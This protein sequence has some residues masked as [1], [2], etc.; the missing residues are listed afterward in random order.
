MS[1]EERTP[2]QWAQELGAELHGM[3]DAKWHEFLDYMEGENKDA[4]PDVAKT[5]L[6]EA[7]DLHAGFH[8]DKWV[9]PENQEERLH[10]LR[11]LRELRAKRLHDV[12]ER[13]NKLYGG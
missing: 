1:E 10:R 7:K 3:S 11:S 9:R 8:A 6:E 4:F 12:N 13:Y 5:L 2:Q